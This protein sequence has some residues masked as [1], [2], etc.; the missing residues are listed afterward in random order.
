MFLPLFLYARIVSSRNLQFAS[1]IARQD[2][3]AKPFGQ[4]H[5]GATFWVT[6]RL[7]VGC[8]GTCTWASASIGIRQS[9][10]QLQFHQSI[11]LIKPTTIW[12][13]IIF[14]N[15][16]HIKR[17]QPI[18]S[19]PWRQWTLW[20]I[21]ITVTITAHSVHCLWGLSLSLRI[22]CLLN[23]D[24]SLK[25]LLQDLIL[26]CSGIARGQSVDHVLDAR[27]EGTKMSI[28]IICKFYSSF[29]LFILMWFLK[30]S[31]INLQDFP[32]NFIRFNFGIKN[33]SSYY[34]LHLYYW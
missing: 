25:A 31:Q 29:R 28:K 5:L 6:S 22:G 11:T 9:S 19:V 23:E 15:T 21:T 7:G 24:N 2:I 8:L 33:M 17:K 26:P 10:I 14:I 30:W 32:K 3:W 13:G 12:G 20:A 1:L 27:D 18:L 16:T 34:E 4:C